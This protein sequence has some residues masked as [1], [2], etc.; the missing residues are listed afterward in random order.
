MNKIKAILLAAGLGTRL[1]PFTDNWP[2]CLMP[3]GDRPLLEYWLEYLKIMGVDNALVNLH[4]HADIVQEFLHRKMYRGWVKS[5][6]EPTLLGTAGTVRANSNF[7]GD[8]T[9][10][11]VHA[12]NW[13]D[14]NWKDFIYC[15]NTQRPSNCPIT[16][17]T[18][19]C[20]KPS[21]CGILEL[22]S[23]GIVVQM[24]EKSENPPGNLANAAV[25]L[26]E[27]EVVKWICDRPS[28]HDF[29]TEVL[30]H[31]M[32]KIVTW[33]NDH[34][35][36]DIGTTE[37]LI[38]SQRDPLPPLSK[39]VEDKWRSAFLSNSIFEMIKKSA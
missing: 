5:V 12:D 38:I 18:F 2:K 16:M 9:L 30:P 23:D 17:M 20:E 36:R 19:V 24:H 10:L 28:I 27:P 39:P 1:R 37:A 34:I 7:I 33:H 22:N 4:Y 29:S 21:T 31:F 6:F 26:I 25:Y 32:G 14:C 13:S 8:E 11:L 35:H 15:H 3:I